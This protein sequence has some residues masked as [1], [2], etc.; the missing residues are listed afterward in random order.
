MPFFT[1]HFINIIIF[2]LTNT[3][4]LTSIHFSR[5]S[6]SPNWKTMNCRFIRTHC[7]EELVW[8]CSARG[9]KLM[10][11]KQQVTKHTRFSSPVISLLMNSLWSRSG[12]GMDLFSADRLLM[13]S[14][15]EILLLICLHFFFLYLETPSIEKLLSKDWKDKL[16]AMGSGN[17]GEIKGNMFAI[18]LIQNVPKWNWYLGLLRVIKS[19]GP[20]CSGWCILCLWCFL[21]PAWKW[22]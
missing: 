9:K 13:S 15:V 1:L 10:I 7:H 21:F 18:L 16:L 3:L 4:K 12:I 19:C 20:S 5:N 11:L 17:F 8:L 22:L 6:R 14:I 2:W